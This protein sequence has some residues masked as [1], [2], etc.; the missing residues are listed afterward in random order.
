VV[1]GNGSSAVWSSTVHGGYSNGL[2]SSTLDAASGALQLVAP[3]LVGARTD[4][5]IVDDSIGTTVTSLTSWNNIKQLSY[6]PIV[7]SVAIVI[8]EPPSWQFLISVNAFVP[9]KTTSTSGSSGDAVADWS[10]IDITNTAATVISTTNTCAWNGIQQVLL[11]DD[12]LM[13]ATSSGLL[14]QV[15]FASNESRLIVDPSFLMIQS[16]VRQGTWQRVVDGCVEAVSTFTESATADVIVDSL[17]PHHPYC[18]S[19]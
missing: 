10:I 6:N 5:A 7:S 1:T 17:V 18:C 19:S 4:V 14:Q 16:T 3:L 13:L 9:S 2:T 12:R 11:L 8:F 15:L